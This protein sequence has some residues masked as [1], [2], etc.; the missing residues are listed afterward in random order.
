MSVWSVYVLRTARESL[1]TGISTAVDARLATHNAGRG[2]RSLRGAL[3]VKLAYQ[4]EIG[5]RSLALKAEYRIKKLGRLQKEDL[6][7][8][9]PNATRLLQ[10]LELEPSSRLGMQISDQPLSN[11]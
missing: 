6:L 9:Q 4:C 3:P 11:Q 2:A 7:Q 5:S 8:T 1:Y 10:L